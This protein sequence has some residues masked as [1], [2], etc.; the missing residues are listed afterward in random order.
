V[1]RAIAICVGCLSIALS[2]PGTAS[3]VPA[4]V[5]DYDLGRIAL[6]DPGPKG[7]VPIRLWGAIGAPAPAAAPGP[8]PL[9]LVLH[10][11]HGTGCPIG[12]G[13]AEV[14]PCFRRE[15]RNDLGLR[16][17]VRALAERGMVA[18]APDLNGA[19]TV[20]WGEPDD[21]RRWPRLVRRVLAE[22]EREAVNGGGGFGL[23]LMGRVDFSRIGLLGHS[24]SG[25]RSVRFARGL[26]GAAVR[27]LFLL[28]PV[29]GGIAL[30]DLPTGIVLSSCDG[31]TGLRG[32]EYLVRA[33]RDQDRR[34]G[35]FLARL[36]RANHNFYNRTLSRLRE[37]DAPPG[38][39]GS[40]LPPG[41]QQRWLDRAAADFF[42]ATLRGAPRPAWLTPGARPPRRVYGQ[43]VLI[44]R[45]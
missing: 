17:V 14:W 27:S 23:P 36:G 15:Q 29:F 7:P 20:G 41:A 24:L 8:R 13:D 6:A 18:V 31:D 40:L 38:C 5:R 39:A 34:R 42:A 4:Q 32:R 19:F 25:H 22:L 1:T 43:Q 30:P 10:G 33:R 26:G 28:A 35:V 3:A 37:N 11:R 21:L 2:V 12:P 45:G 44:R 9:V 16:H